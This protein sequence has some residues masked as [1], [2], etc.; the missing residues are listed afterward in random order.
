MK[1]SNSKKQLARIILENG[2]WR[3]RAEFSAQDKDGEVFH[4]VT[5]PTIGVSHE[6]WHHKGCIGEGEFTAEALPHWHR[7]ILS[8]DEYFHL[9]PVAETAPEPVVE[10]KPAIE[11]RAADYRNAK[12][13]AERKQQEA[14]AAKADAEA[15]L[16]ELVVAGEALGLVV[17]VA[18]PEPCEDGWVSYDGGGCPVGPNEA[19][20]VFLRKG[21]PSSRGPEAASMWDWTVDGAGGDIIKW[22]KVKGEANS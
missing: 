17:S 8:R 10:A 6:V 16:A 21:R 7:T 9:Y 2:G 22:R 14:D 15:K 4:Y 1:I 20:E 12:D 5:K 19:V 18:G 11:Q 13:Y 3:E